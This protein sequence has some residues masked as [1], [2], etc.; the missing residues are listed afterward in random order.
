MA[1]LP[2]PGDVVGGY[3]F[4]GGDPA[5]ESSWKPVA[6]PSAATVPSPAAAPALQGPK[7]GDVAN[8]YQFTG[9]DPGSAENWKQLSGEDFLKTLSPTQQSLIQAMVRGDIKPP[10][11]F[12]L[13]KPYW[14]QAI[15]Q[16][17]QYD[18]NFSET[19]WPTR[20]AM[21]KDVAGS[22]KFGQNLNALNTAIQ[23]TALLANS[24]PEVWGT[25][26]PVVGKAVNAAGN[27]LEDWGGD[28]GITKY[29][30]AVNALGHEL[31]RTYAQTGAGS[32]ADLDTFMEG[33]GENLSTEQKKAALQQQMQLLAGKAN[34][35]WEQYQQS[36]GG[37]APPLHVL[38]PESVKA[39]RAMG[40]DPADLG[41]DKNSY[42][43]PPSKTPTVTTR[44]QFDK[45]P[46]GTEYIGKD[47]KRYRKP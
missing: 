38:A 40:M 11:D 45:L 13:T 17:R 43:E 44:Q 33:M 34:S 26:I 16:A 31:R 18:P 46:S 3:R 30:N 28:P 22:G 21:R 47:G 25:Q 5:Q 39:L 35:I 37:Y 36:M 4:Q 10:T 41:F 19:L 6:Q 12:A 20:V 14:Q 8:G 9:G 24:I 29:R 2:Q 1:D 23:H 27:T 42:A 32:Q 7:V 15:S